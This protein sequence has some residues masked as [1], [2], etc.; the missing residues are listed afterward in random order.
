MDRLGLLLERVVTGGMLGL[1]VLGVDC[2]VMMFAD[3]VT[4]VVLG[5]GFA[6]QVPTYLG[7]KQRER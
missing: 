4:E 6:L 3:E 1:L 5:A 7:E 2:L